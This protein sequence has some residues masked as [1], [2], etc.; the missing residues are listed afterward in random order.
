VSAERATEDVAAFVEQL[1]ALGAAEILA[2]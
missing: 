2:L 1:V